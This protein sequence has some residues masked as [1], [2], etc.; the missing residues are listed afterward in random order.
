MERLSTTTS[1]DG[2]GTANSRERI[3]YRANVGVPRTRVSKTKTMK[4]NNGQ[5]HKRSGD[6]KRV[7][8]E[9]GG[10]ERTGWRGIMSRQKRRGTLAYRRRGQVPTSKQQGEAAG[11]RLSVA[12][13]LDY[14]SKGE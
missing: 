11:P 8:R 7:V 3:V 5:V 14:L 1:N 2:D 12:S 13:R 9:D 4:E 6:S 10:R